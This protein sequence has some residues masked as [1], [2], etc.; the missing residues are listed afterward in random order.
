M[1]NKTKTKNETNTISKAVLKTLSVI[2]KIKKPTRTVIGFILIALGSFLVI[3]GA[4]AVFPQV[5][6][7]ASIFTGVFVLIL[8][9]LWRLL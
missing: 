5:S 7:I 2:S 4:L 3:Q 1:K 9:G 6:G 8:A